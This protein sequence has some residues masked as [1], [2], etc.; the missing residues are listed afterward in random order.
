MTARGR[1][2][3]KT[4]WCHFHHVN[5][6]YVRELARDFS[7]SSRL[8]EHVR[9]RLFLFSHGLGRLLPD[10]HVLPLLTPSGPSRTSA[11]GKAGTRSPSEV[12]WTR[13]A[14]D[15]NPGA[16]PGSGVRIQCLAAFALP[17][18]TQK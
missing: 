2:C 8:L 17:Q 3:V 13:T 7:N 16:R 6:G 9:G 10:W 14:S 5:F 12:S 18:D 11:S 1:E 4:L 15:K